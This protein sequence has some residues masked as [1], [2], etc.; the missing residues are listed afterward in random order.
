MI[1]EVQRR[2][3]P[4]QRRSAYALVRRGSLEQ[5][6]QEEMEALRAMLAGALQPRPSSRRTPFTFLD[7]GFASSPA[8]A[9]LST[10]SAFSFCAHAETNTPDYEPDPRRG[11]FLNN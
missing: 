10:H 2:R 7:N 11:A 5:M 1:S 3:C 6:I 8:L 4:D 9:A